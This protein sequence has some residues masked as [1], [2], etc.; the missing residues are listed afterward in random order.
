MQAV[1]LSGPAANVALGNFR[2]RLYGTFDLDRSQADAATVALRCLLDAR[3]HTPN[4]PLLLPQVVDWAWHELVIDTTRYTDICDELYDGYM[5]HAIRSRTPN[6]AAALD[7][8]FRATT[9]LFAQKYGLDMT[10]YG[11][12]DPGW[13]QPYRLRRPCV[14]DASLG[15]T[16][17]DHR[18]PNAARGAR[19]D[20]SWLSARLQHR[21]RMNPYQAGQTLEMYRAFLSSAP[22]PETG[23]L[24]PTNLAVDAAWREHILWTRRYHEDCAELFGVYYQR[25]L[26]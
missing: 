9:D 4:Q 2:D 21:W 19:L 11:W 26:H 5:H 6:S 12:L 16:S 10:S 13:G 14:W 7:A 25:R 3:T 24:A 18:G 23:S 22:S 17:P 8:E 20:L 15:T 1:L